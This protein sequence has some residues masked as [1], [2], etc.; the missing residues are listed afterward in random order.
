MTPTRV[1]NF[2]AR[3]RKVT[4]ISFLVTLGVSCLLLI[5]PVYSGQTS[6]NSGKGNVT[7]QTHATLLEVNGTSVLIPLAIPVLIVSIPTI[8]QHSWVRI[9]A[10]IVLYIFV[11]IG[12]Y[13]IGLF[14]APSAVC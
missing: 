14:Y 5:V 12:G 3:A 8:F 4:T 10:T 1:G 2:P 11:F 13:S 9:G 7:V 6:V